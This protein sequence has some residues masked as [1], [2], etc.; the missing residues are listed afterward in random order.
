METAII[1]IE[2]GLTDFQ[3]FCAVESRL[4]SCI[5]GIVPDV[6]RM[7]QILDEAG[8]VYLPRYRLFLL[9]T[10]MKQITETDVWQRFQS[11]PEVTVRDLLRLPLN[12]E[13]VVKFLL[14]ERWEK[15]NKIL[16]K[17]AMRESLPFYATNSAHLLHTPK[18]AKL[19]TEL[20]HPEP[21]SDALLQREKNKE[22]AEGGVNLHP[23][24]STMNQQRFALN[25]V[26]VFLPK[27]TASAAFQFKAAAYK[28]INV[29][30][31]GSSIQAVAL[32]SRSTAA[33]E[34][35]VTLE[36][37]EEWT[38]WRMSPDENTLIYYKRLEPPLSLWEGAIFN[39]RPETAVFPHSPMEFQVQLHADCTVNDDGDCYVQQAGRLVSGQEGQVYM[40][41]AI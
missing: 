37:E 35:R 2:L 22:R 12:V 20:Y 36:H 27:F 30:A 14:L 28:D 23:L 4:D 5:N 24:F 7:I 19:L 41:K 29:F 3:T 9:N 33:P 31:A 15:D 18:I 6:V 39:I 40:A 1:L 17:V 34:I 11:L 10:L 16:Q 25:E 38:E 13:P 26:N 21:L 8:H 32:I